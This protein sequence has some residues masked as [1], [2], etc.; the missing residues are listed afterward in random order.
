MVAQRRYE[1]TGLSGCLQHGLSRLSLDLLSIDS[2]I[3]DR[4]RITASFQLSTVSASPTGL[5]SFM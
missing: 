2:E 5:G 4:H 1:N 3:H